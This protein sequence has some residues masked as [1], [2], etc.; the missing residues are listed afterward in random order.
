MALL[1]LNNQLL[2]ETLKKNFKKNTL[3]L[4]NT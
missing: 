2:N 4:N 3:G 1:K